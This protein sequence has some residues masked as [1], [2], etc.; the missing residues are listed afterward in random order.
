MPDITSF[1]ENTNKFHTW[2]SENFEKLSPK[3]EIADLRDTN[4]G[5]G[6]IAKQDIE[7]D[8]VLFEM[9]R[10]AILNIETS[11]L[12][13]INPE[14]AEKLN[15]LTQ[16][17]SLILVLAYE[18][19][20]GSESKWSPYF[21]VLP[22][23]GFN[24]L[25][26]WNDEE[27]EHLKPSRVLSRIGKK[28]AEEMY[29]KLVP[30]QCEELGVPELAK[31]L[32]LEKFHVVAS[33]IMSYSFDVDR[34]EEVDLV[35]NGELEKET[36]ELEEAPE[37]EPTE[38]DDK[39][40]NSSSNIEDEDE[41]EEDD[42]DEDEEQSNIIKNDTFLKSMVPLAD[43]LNANTTL[44]NAT[45]KYTNHKLSMTATKP[46]P[47]GS[48]IYNIY[49]DLPNSEILRKYGYIELPNSQHEFAEI[50]IELVKQHYLKFP[51]SKESKHASALEKLNASQ[52]LVDGVLE[53]IDESE[54]LDMT[55]V[56]CEGSIVIESYEVF[57][58]G[59]V[60]LELTVLI[61]VLS[62]LF[63]AFQSDFKWLKKLL[64]GVGKEDSEFE[65]FVNRTIMKC[66]QLIEDGM[67]NR[68]ALD[69]LHAILD[70][71]L[72][73]YPE[74]I[75]NG[76][77]EVPEQYGDFSKEKLANIVLKN[78]VDVLNC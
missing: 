33:I 13:K 39:E 48:Q 60:L 43:T 30:G 58:D 47:A 31:F 27:L 63:R 44:F 28:E 54:F 7:E 57:K 52:K 35:E 34:P 42:D 32:T 12:S 38:D 76:G 72:K 62:T 78:E 55:L 1:T 10:D 11:Q 5:R 17:E 37:V 65:S 77:F 69:D 40:D 15:N 74:E 8:E 36:D 73:Q 9:S 67:L 75:V 18:M 4:Q 45:L 56:D 23:G 71:R 2:L 51:L 14:N 59:E 50:P 16:W 20:L 24:S 41:E 61:T 6:L 26:F 29:H 22:S 25:M 46:I 66:Y 3:I 64:R 21:D 70:A 19:M 53:L 49:G 68:G